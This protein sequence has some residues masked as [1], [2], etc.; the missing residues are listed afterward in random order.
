MGFPSFEI[1]KDNFRDSQGRQIRT[2]DKE[3]FDSKV[4]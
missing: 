2:E 3:S 4:L 1:E